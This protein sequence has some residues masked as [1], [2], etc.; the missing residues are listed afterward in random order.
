MNT[1][2]DSEAKPLTGANRYV[3]HFQNGGL[4]PA[5]VFWSITLYDSRHNL[6]AN[7]IKRY[8]IG[9]RDKLKFNGDSSL[10]IYVQHTSPGPDREAN[11]LPSPAEDF[12]LVMRAYLPGV[13]MQEQ[14]WTPP[15][16]Q[17]I[18]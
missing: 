11:W 14:R 17:K 10:D 8:S 13:E 12:N 15:P 18:N 9:D 16:V 6:I 7:P 2:N 1:S 4:P 5:K 3:I